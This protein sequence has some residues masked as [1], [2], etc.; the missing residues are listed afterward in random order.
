MFL[1]VVAVVH[2]GEESGEY[3][4]DDVEDDDDD[5]DD[6]NESDEEYEDGDDDDQLDEAHSHSHLYEGEPYNVLY[7]LM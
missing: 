6:G 7:L 1:H 5:D 3:E 2:S 4:D